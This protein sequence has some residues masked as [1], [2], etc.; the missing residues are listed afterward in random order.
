M[1]KNEQRIAIA[2]KCGYLHGSFKEGGGCVWYLCDSNGNIIRSGLPNFPKNLNAMHEAEK[3]LSKDELGDY[4]VVLTGI[5]MQ[6]KSG[7]YFPPHEGM[8]FQVAHA[9][10]DQKSEAFSKTLWPERF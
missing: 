5:C 3:A 1:T 8:V 4:E 6:A 7:F 10:A 2:E 9:A